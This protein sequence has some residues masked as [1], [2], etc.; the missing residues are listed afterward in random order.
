MSVCEAYLKW[1]PG[2]IFLSTKA[3]L[4]R[5]AILKLIKTFE[6][7]LFLKIQYNVW[8]IIKQNTSAQTT[9]TLQHDCDDIS[10]Q[11]QAP[12]HLAPYLPPEYIQDQ[13]SDFWQTTK[14]D[15]NVFH[16]QINNLQSLKNNEKNTKNVLNTSIRDE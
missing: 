15:L 12:K 3:A 8:Q 10:L 1:L 7:V 2:E 6:N 14:D 13:A 4:M 16:R 9:S 5:S 11:L